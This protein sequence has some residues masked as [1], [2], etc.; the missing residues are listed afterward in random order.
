MK[1]MDK[2]CILLLLIGMAACAH[3]SGYIPAPA[4][5]GDR[6]AKIVSQ[7]E[8][9]ASLMTWKRSPYWRVQDFSWPWDVIVADDGTACPLFEQVVFLPEVRG[10]YVCPT[11]WR[12]IRP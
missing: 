6:N 5:A 3:G 7:I 1:F 12:F 10:Y 2:L 9:Y 4:R 11:S 8:S